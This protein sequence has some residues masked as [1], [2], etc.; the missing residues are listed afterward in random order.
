MLLMTLLA[1]LANA[2]TTD[3]DVYTDG[4]A[5]LV[6]DASHTN[7]MTIEVE[8]HNG[9][10]GTL[11]CQLQDSGSW[12]YCGGFLSPVP[13]TPLYEIGSVRA[14]ELDLAGWSG[15]VVGFSVV[16]QGDHEPE[17]CSIFADV[18]NLL[19]EA[20]FGEGD[21]EMTDDE[22]FGEFVEEVSDCQDHDCVE[23]AEDNLEECVD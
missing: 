22:C 2:S 16:G 19:W 15:S 1:T 13:V 3:L 9:A 18:F 4:P 14:V 23:D 7:S 17:A 21:A 6:Y 10:T 5:Y 12:L 20:A 11:E 8:A